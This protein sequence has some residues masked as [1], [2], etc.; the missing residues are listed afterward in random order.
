MTLKPLEG[1]RS[2]GTHHCV[3]GS[4]RHVYE[5]H[6]YPVSE[7]LLLGLGAGV[8]FIYWHTKGTTPFYG[9]RG[10]VERPGHE[11]LEVT[12]G[13]RLGV[14][15]EHFRTSSARKAEKA[16]LEMLGAGEPVMLELDMGFLPYLNLPDG[17]HFGAHA[18]V[19]AGYDPETRMVLIADRD[20]ELHAVSMEDLAK[21]RG[22]TFKPFPPKHKWYTFNFSRRR[23]SEPEDVRQAIREVVTGMLEPPITNFGVKGIRKAAKRTLKW[24]EIMSEEELRFTC[25]N[26]FVFIDAIGGT[27][28]GI[29]RY[30]YARFL[31][32]AAGITDDTRL[33]ERADEFQRIGDKW[34]ALAEIFMNASKADDPAAILPGVKAPLLDLANLE[35]AAWS[36]L[37][38]LVR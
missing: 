10:N 13:K 17:Y 32:E 5:F 4:M 6:G 33:N 9:G 38:E 28:G 2:L 15:T 7:E 23:P 1:F 22:S 24:P 31:R 29:F 11:G 30:M 3:T 25:F 21:A 34:Q 35:D 8:G 19:V 27:G 36:R 37:G 14:R 16:L 18:V 20:G 26:I 12:A